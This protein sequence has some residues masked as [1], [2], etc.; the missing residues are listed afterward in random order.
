[1]RPILPSGVKFIIDRLAENGRSAHI[2]GGCVRDFLLAKEPFDYDITT[3]A[4]PNEMKAIFSDVKTVETGIKHGTL[5]VICGDGQYE[6]T[7]YRIDG[8]YEDHRHPKSVS[9]TSSL[10]ADLS[11]R[12]F[13]MNAICYNEKDGFID[14]FSGIDDIKNKIIRAVGEPE[15][16]FSEDALRILRAIR[17]SSTLGF[18][19]EEKTAKAA[20]TCAPLLSSVSGERIYSEWSKLIGG[21]YAYG[22][23]SEF[24]EIL[25]EF[26]FWEKVVLPPKELFSCA[27]VTVR[28][29]SLFALSFSD[30]A[31]AF[32]DFCRRMRTDSKTQ[33][34]GEAVLSSL[35]L[36]AKTEKDIKLLI[37]KLGA[38]AARVLIELKIACSLISRDA[39]AAFD[40]AAHSGAPFSVKE[41]AVNGTDISALGFLGEDIGRI[42]KELLYLTVEE[43]LKNEREEL[44][45]AAAKFLFSDKDKV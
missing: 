7:T 29:L 14:N 33:K 16:R 10:F 23:I 22:V 40:S 1:M 32:T 43:N 37:I 24:S 35:S 3:N 28:Q 30:S 17:F 27:S 19:I 12:D 45:R 31:P 26:L 34:M 42:L 8:E 4:V 21:E 41:L 38:E 36:P 11:R 5:T 18:S 6:V 9:F 39:L 2:V 44:L 25:K 20:R 13:T 15:L